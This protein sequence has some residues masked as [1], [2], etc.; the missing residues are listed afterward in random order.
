VTG[1][2]FTSTPTTFRGVDL[3]S[4]L[5]AIRNELS[6]RFGNGSDPRVRGV[7]VI[8]QGDQIL[9]P[10][11]TT[12]YSVQASGGIQYEF[13][14]NWIFTADYVL[15]KYYHVGPLQNTYIID[16]NRFNRPRVTGVNPNTGVVS[17]VRDPVIPLC[18]AA[19]SAAL[20][21]QD[22]C[23]TGPINVFS[24]GAQYRYQG[25]HLKLDRRF[26]SG[27]QLFGRVRLFTGHR[28]F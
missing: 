16:R 12:S 2:N 26:S 28:F 19:Q 14:S 1:L 7:E 25:L 24:S 3:L 27:L 18:S 8:K 5:P 22:Q 13:G 10:D 9:D 6:S 11:V 4:R 17:F 21:P 15:R 20:N 23:S